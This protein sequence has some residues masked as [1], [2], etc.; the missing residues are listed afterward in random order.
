MQFRRMDTADPDA[1]AALQLEGIAIGYISNPTG[2]RCSNGAVSGRANAPTG[3]D[4]LIG[5]LFPRAADHDSC[6]AAD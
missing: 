6:L 3:K 4:S 2:D 1:F 5:M